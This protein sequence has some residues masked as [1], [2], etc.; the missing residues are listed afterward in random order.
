MSNIDLRFY[1][2]QC[3]IKASRAYYDHLDNCIY[4]R[5]PNKIKSKF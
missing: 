3:R 4:M 2:L 1:G 5:K